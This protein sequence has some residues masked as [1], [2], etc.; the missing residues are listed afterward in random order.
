MHKCRTLVSKS[1]T[2]KM[3]LNEKAVML[4][5]THAYMQKIAKISS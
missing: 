2:D 4:H 3:R 1:I 5:F